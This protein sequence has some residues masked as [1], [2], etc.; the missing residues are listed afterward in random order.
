MPRDPKNTV[1]C[2]IVQVR[3]LTFRSGA[4]SRNTAKK[5][6]LACSH[7]LRRKMKYLFVA[8]WSLVLGA[9]SAL[10]QG[11]YRIVAGDTVSIEV[12]EDSSL[13]RTLLVL[14]DGTVNFPF[15]GSVRVAGRTVGEVERVITA[16]IANNFA[17]TPTV[18][19]TVSSVFIEPTEAPLEVPEATISVY[20]T[21]E[22]NR[23]GLTPMVPGTTFLQAVAQSGGFTRFAAT[24]RISLRRN[25]PQTGQPQVF[26]INYKALADGAILERAIILQD[27]DVILVPERRLFE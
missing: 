6:A 9:T 5:Q 19:V 11:N 3:L 15:A 14:P 1:T 26:T 13:D 18:F 12:L 24:K 25:D 16:Q 21:G 20:F 23:P 2:H 4:V 7:G 27:G 10:A 17:T 8:F 22:V